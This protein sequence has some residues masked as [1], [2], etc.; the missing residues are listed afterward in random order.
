MLEIV[1]DDVRGSFE[2]VLVMVMV[3]LVWNGVKLGD[4][5]KKQEMIVLVPEINER[6]LLTDR[7]LGDAVMRRK[8][9]WASIDVT[10]INCDGGWTSLQKTKGGPFSGP[11]MPASQG[12]S[13]VICSSN[14][15]CSAFPTIDM[16]FFCCC[17]HCCRY[18]VAVWRCIRVANRAPVVR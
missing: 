17:R 15:G 5:R 2:G 16:L 9:V 4:G 12:M 18:D 14:G 11:R 10:T 8:S 1:V 6:I 13:R 7:L 3:M